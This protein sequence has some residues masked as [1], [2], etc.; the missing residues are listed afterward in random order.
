[1]VVDV[2]QNRLNSDDAD[3]ETGSLLVGICWRDGGRCV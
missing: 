1:M 3:D 2:V